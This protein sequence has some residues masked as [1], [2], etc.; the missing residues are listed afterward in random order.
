METKEK[1]H[2]F[3]QTAIQLSKNILLSEETSSPPLIHIVQMLCLH[4]EQ[5]SSLLRFEIRV[6]FPPP[7]PPP[8]PQPVIGG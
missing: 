1:E 5:S 2:F 8:P 3:S 4:F 7:T 6:Q